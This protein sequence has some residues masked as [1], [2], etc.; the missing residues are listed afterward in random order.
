[1][2]QYWMNARCET[3]LFSNTNCS[4]AEQLAGTAAPLHTLFEKKFVL[5]CS[6]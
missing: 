1:M 6:V 3:L 2:I 4:Q 5:I